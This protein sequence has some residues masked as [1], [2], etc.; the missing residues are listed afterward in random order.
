MHTY[1]LLIYDKGRERIDSAL[2]GTGPPSCPLAL[3]FIC[4]QRKWTWFFFL[5]IIVYIPKCNAYFVPIYAE[6]ST[7]GKFNK[8]RFITLSLVSSKKVSL[9]LKTLILLQDW[10]WE[11]TLGKN[12]QVVQTKVVC[13]PLW[14]KVVRWAQGGGY[15]SAGHISNKGTWSEMSSAIST[16]GRRGWQ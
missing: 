16:H 14:L 7:I 4:K 1:G 5:C 10:N 13:L 6:K 11:L 2:N 3:Y 8:N 9:S 15:I 12:G